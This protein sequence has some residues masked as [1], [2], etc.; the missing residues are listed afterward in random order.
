M[1]RE[2]ID[3]LVV[4]GQQTAYRHVGDGEIPL[5]QKTMKILDTLQQVDF[6]NSSLELFLE[7]CRVQ[8][9]KTFFNFIKPE[10]EA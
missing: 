10:L 3:H 7:V 9:E 2:E 8:W 5:V 6:L 4:T 1:K